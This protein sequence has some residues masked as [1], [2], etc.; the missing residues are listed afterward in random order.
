MFF[1]KEERDVF[2]FY[3]KISENLVVKILRFICVL[4]GFVLLFFFFGG[5]IKCYFK[6]CIG[7]FFCDI[8]DGLIVVKISIVW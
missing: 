3:W 1:K 4:F 8:M 7:R 5:V 6:E 2:C